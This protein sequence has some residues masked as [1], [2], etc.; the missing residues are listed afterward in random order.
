MIDGYLHLQCRLDLLQVARL[1]CKKAR[2]GFK[3]KMATGR[4][5]FRAVSRV[6]FESD[7]TQATL[8][9]QRNKTNDLEQV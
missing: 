9:I 3:D 8:P 1:M 5:I 4:D 6:R 7:L 2:A